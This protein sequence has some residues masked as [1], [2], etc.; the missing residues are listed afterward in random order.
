MLKSASIGVARLD[1]ERRCLY[2]KDHLCK[3]LCRPRE[4]LLGRAWHDGFPP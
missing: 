2:A 4:P 3:I 1:P